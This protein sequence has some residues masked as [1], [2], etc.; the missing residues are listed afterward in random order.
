MW[1]LL[2]RY[3]RSCSNVTD[4]KCELNLLKILLLIEIEAKIREEKK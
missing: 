3:I 4:E 2:T 1:S